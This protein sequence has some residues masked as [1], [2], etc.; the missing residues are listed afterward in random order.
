MKNKQ[1]A[2]ESQEIQTHQPLLYQH[3]NRAR[4]TV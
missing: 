2:L 1:I 4:N 3:Q